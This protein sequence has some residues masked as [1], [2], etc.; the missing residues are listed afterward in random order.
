[1]E[2]LPELPRDL[3]LQRRRAEPHEALLETL[4]LQGPLE[5]FLDDEDH[6]MAAPAQHIPDTDAVVG[7]SERSLGEE[8]DGFRLHRWIVMESREGGRPYISSAS[9]TRLSSS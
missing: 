6:A 9:A 5:R 7:R 8:D 4:G 1:N 2:L 3:G